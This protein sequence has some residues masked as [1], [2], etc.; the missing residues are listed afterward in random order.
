[1]A[2]EAD[3]YELL[4]V[5]K[6]A[7]SDEMKRAY[8]KLAKQYHP[9]S[10]TGEDKKKAEEKFKEISTA[11]SVLSDETKRAQY[12]R[13]GSGFENAGFGGGAGGFNGSGFGGF[14]FSGF[15]AGG[16]DIDLEDI[17][18]SVFGG[19]FGS[20]SKNSNRPIKGADIR[21]NMNLTF[22]EAIFGCTKTISVQRTEKCEDCHGSGAKAGTSSVT[23]D[24]CGG[25]GKIQVVQNTI[26]GAFSSTRECDKCRRNR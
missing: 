7:S 14:D 26:M 1:M 16:M 11:Y 23:C 15:S 17:L 6:T 10:Y 25:K 2:K 24:K 19:G 12:D 5:S 18:G 22:E 9:D 3:Y 20:S 13:F 8:R 4:G 21:Y